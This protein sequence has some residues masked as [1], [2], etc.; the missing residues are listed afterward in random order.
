MELLTKFSNKCPTYLET[1]WD[2]L[3]EGLWY[4]PMIMIVIHSANSANIG[5]VIPLHQ[6]R[7]LLQHLISQL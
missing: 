5:K 1:I 2:E 4:V 3:K 6:L 7:L